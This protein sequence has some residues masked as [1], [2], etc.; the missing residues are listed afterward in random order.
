MPQT[1][2]GKRNGQPVWPAY[3]VAI[4]IVGFALAV[5]N[6]PFI[7]AA[8]GAAI[9]HPGIFP[10]AFFLTLLGIPTI[11]ADRWLIGW[12]KDNLQVFHWTNQSLHKGEKS[13]RPR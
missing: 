10:A 2:D 1:G 13:D 4:I 6:A 3:A 8:A 7:I 9:Y 11:F 12:L 5:V